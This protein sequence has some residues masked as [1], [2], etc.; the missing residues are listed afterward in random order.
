M[1][2]TPAAARA[3]ERWVADVSTQLVEGLRRRVEDMRAAGTDPRSL[4]TPDELVDRMLAVVPNRSPW[5]G[6]GPFY[7]TR[8]VA[9]VLGGITRQAIE[10]RRRRHRIV[11]LRTA[12]G[13]WVYPAFQFGDDNRIVPGLPKVLATLSKTG[14]SDWTVASMLVARQPELGRRSIVEH[15][16][17][18]RPLEPVL[19]LCRAAVAVVAEPR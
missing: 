11:A 7:S 8:A 13:G 9:Q 16:R 12:D 18:G 6:L 1:S 5:N 14:L 17:D 2:R 10:D 3:D 19:A 4:G 15:L